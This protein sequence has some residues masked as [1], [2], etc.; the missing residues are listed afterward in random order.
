MSKPL[1]TV[2]G[3]SQTKI[4]IAAKMLFISFSELKADLEAAVGNLA[5][6][7]AAVWK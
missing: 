1:S 4:D 5:S 2:S 3:L 7:S 6:P